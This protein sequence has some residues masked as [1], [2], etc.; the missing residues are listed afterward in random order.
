MDH[1]DQPG[2]LHAGR[3]PRRSGASA[4]AR[5]SSS[6]T[7][8]RHRHRSA[9]RMC[10][11]PPRPG[12]RRTAPSPIRSGASRASARFLPRPARRG[13]IGGSSARSPSAWASARP[14]P[15]AAPAE[16][17]AEHAA[18]SAFE[19]DGTRDFD[20]GAFAGIDG[21]S[22]EALQPFQWPRPRPRRPPDAHLRRRPLLH[23]RPQGAL[24]R[25][26]ATARRAAHDAAFPLILNTGRVRDHWH[27]MTRTGKSPRLSQHCAEPFVEIHPED[28]QRF[29]S[30]TPTRARLDRAR[31]GSRARA[32]CRPATAGH[33][34]RADALDRP[35]RLRRAASTRSIPAITDPIPASRPRSMC[36]SASSASPR[37]NTASRCSASGRR[38]R[39]RV[40]GDCQ[41]RR[42][43]ARRAWLC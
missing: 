3:R 12:A 9:S 27:T 16:I 5:S 17:F 14:S 30:P 4:P 1:G 26:F 23:A 31:R 42:R 34:L 24:R 39:L 2:R 18:L 41:M 20:I 29:A 13:P 6:P 36:R 15:I 38:A 43:L 37:R 11:C 10:A 25:R 19:N 21:E 40:L 8:R 22:Y 32:W 7:C 28:A 35:V 33:D